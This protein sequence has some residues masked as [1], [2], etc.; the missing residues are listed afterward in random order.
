MR[1]LGLLLLTATTIAG[2]SGAGGLEIMPLDDQRV[3][4]NDTL[5]IEL[6]VRTAVGDE[7][8]SFSAPSIPDIQRSGAG[9]FQS[10]ASATFRWSP[11]AS[12]AGMH[13]FTFTVTSGGASDSETIDVE[14]IQS[15]GAPT[16][17]EPSLG[18]AYDLSRNACI[19]V[20]IVVADQDDTRVEISEREP[21]I[22]GGQLSQT[23]NFRAQ[24]HWCPTAQQVD[25]TLRYTLHL[26]AS[27]THS[28]PV[29]HNHEIVLLNEQKPDCPGA[30]PQIVS[31]TAEARYETVQ[32]YAVRATVTDDQGLKETPILY[33]STTQPDMASPDVTRMDTVTFA[34]ESG[35]SYV[36]YVPNL[37]LTVGQEQTVYYVVSATDNDD[38]EGT[39][40]DHRTMST[41]GSFVAVEPTNPDLAGYCEP[42]TADRQCENGLCVAAT[43]SFC[44][45]DC[46]SGCAEGA[47]Q[48][49]SSVSGSSDSQCV[50]EGMRCGGA[51]CADDAYEPASNAMATAPSFT[52][53]DMLEGSICPDDED[54]YAL[55]LTAGTTYAFT[56]TGWAGPADI[57]I[58][59]VDATPDLVAW[60]DGTTDVEMFEYCPETSGSYYLWVMA[61]TAAPGDYLVEVTSGGSCSATTCTDDYE[62]NDG[63][64]SAADIDCGG[65]ET[66]ARICEGDEDWYQVFVSG[67]ADIEVVLGCEPGG[68][69]IDLF[70]KDD[71]GTTLASSLDD[72][73]EES[74]SATL[75]RGGS[76]FIRLDGVGA[77]TAD[78]SFLCETSAGSGCTATSACPSGTVC[79]G[80]AG[81]VDD[82]CTTPGGAECPADHFCPE[83]GGW[84]AESACVDA[85]WSAW[86]C[87]TGYE[88]KAF[89]AGER[90]CAMAGP[91][92]TG[93]LCEGF[94]DC[95]GE[96]T[97]VTTDGYCAEVAC[98]T[99]ADCPIDDPDPG[100]ARCVEIGGGQTACLKDCAWGEDLC[101]S[102]MGSCVETQDV[103]GDPR[104]V[105]AAAAMTVPP[106]P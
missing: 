100:D 2:C 101:L 80:A 70:V 46:G 48:T 54:F 88:C 59:L 92:T 95:A 5:I 76:Y 13:Q 99:N 56:A 85:C 52:I 55:S 34:R 38:A 30:S 36:A 18:A 15:G 47:C 37:N 79:D 64:T 12:Q 50:P 60:S 25:A 31:V 27:D 89:G 77:A 106:A 43:P 87:R 49:V 39:A 83:P 97:C 45:V 21:R 51:A 82:A 16:F 24:W 61:A 26:E 65:E 84:A 40:C 41:V 67:P 7:E 86:D 69:D 72:G 94:W 104:W 28:P 6:R 102:T 14:V 22:E 58:A 93:E 42:C 11:L 1:R 17:T 9:I 4:V 33:Y 91:G 8:W 103:G 74:V 19:D 44:G 66:I 71:A 63:S 35:D 73:C 3:R 57:D 32:D 81:C 78:Y 53:G 62:E 20:N 75:P 23:D 90:G 29:P 96:R 98:A 10:G 105:C 68:G